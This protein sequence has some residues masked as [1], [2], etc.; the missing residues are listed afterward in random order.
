MRIADYEETFRG[1]V[2]DI[3]QQEFADRAIYDSFYAE[4]TLLKRLTQA[5]NRLVIAFKG[6]L[7]G[8]LLEQQRECIHGSGCVVCVARVQGRAICSNCDLGGGACTCV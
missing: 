2:H 1:A 6:R 4:M 8:A 3:L 5:E 7:S